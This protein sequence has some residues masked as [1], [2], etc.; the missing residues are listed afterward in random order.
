MKCGV[1]GAEYHLSLEA[2]ESEAR[3][4]KS[5]EKGFAVVEII[6]ITLFYLVAVDFM[7]P[8]GVD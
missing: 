8:F 2:G 4:Q 3:R 5:G 1:A 7:G 6:L